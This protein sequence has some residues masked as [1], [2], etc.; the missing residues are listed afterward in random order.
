MGVM[1]ARRKTSLLGMLTPRLLKVSE[2]EI[3]VFEI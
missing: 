3:L 1:L 2:L